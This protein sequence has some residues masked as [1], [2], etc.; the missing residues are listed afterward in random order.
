MLYI[1]IY[2]LGYEGVIQESQ[3]IY[4]GICFWLVVDSV[5]FFEKKC[6]L[7]R[8]WYDQRGYLVQ[9]FLGLVVIIFSHFKTVEDAVFSY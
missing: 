3:H 2:H 8:I 4:L 9:I 7:T 6:D 1:K 5:L